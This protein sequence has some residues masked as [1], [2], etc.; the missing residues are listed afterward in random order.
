M[1]K[2]L[3]PCRRSK[4]TVP[5]VDPESIAIVST[6][7]SMRCRETASTT[8]GSVSPPFR[9]GMTIEILLANIAVNDVPRVGI[10]RHRAHPRPCLDADGQILEAPR[11]LHQRSERRFERA[12]LVRIVQKPRAAMLD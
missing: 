12:G 9:V 10:L 5:S 8:A 11:R 2:T 7:T 6:G 1:S 4:A 3:T